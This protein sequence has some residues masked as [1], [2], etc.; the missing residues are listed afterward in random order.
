MYIYFVLVLLF[1]FLQQTNNEYTTPIIKHNFY[2]QT[3][4][5]QRRVAWDF[6]TP[7]A[8]FFK[9]FVYIIIFNNILYY[10]ISIFFLL[11]NVV[12][13]ISKNLIGNNV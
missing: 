1:H 8:Q 12:L 4:S 7:L 13:S 9:H 3:A 5:H 10:F 6:T 11:P 2:T